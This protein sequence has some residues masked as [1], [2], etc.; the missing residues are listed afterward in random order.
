MDFS[1]NAKPVNEKDVAGPVIEAVDVCKERV[2][3]H[4]GSATGSSGGSCSAFSSKKE[5]DRVLQELSGRE[6]NTAYRSGEM[7]GGCCSECPTGGLQTHKKVDL[8]AALTAFVARAPAERSALPLPV[9]ATMP[10][11]RGEPTSQSSCSSCTS[12]SCEPCSAPFSSAAMP[13]ILDA[14]RVATSTVSDSSKLSV[15]E[16]LEILRKAVAENSGKG[17]G[18]EF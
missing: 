11:N 10:L 5:L 17:P 4:F 18:L 16:A 15:D 9:N 14:P 6:T 7:D 1:S 3:A 8:G 13:A 12:G 2:H